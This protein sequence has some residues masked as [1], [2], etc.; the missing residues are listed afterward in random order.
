MKL[1]NLDLNKLRTFLVVADCESVT[2]AAAGLGLTRSAVSQ[3]LSSLE[4]A[5]GVQ[6]F[7]R[8][9]R[10]LLP[11]RE[12]RVLHAQL[13]VSLG[14]LEHALAD[15]VGATRAVR[16]LA[17]VGLFLGFSRVRLARLVAVFATRH[18]GARLKVL[19]A[20]QESLRAQLLHDRLDFVFSLGSMTGKGE[21]IRSERLLLQELVLVGSPQPA[22]GKVDLQELRRMPIVDY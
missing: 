22:R 14:H 6:L 1:N 10:R 16:G 9:A 8:V 19:Y 18:P 17:R 21:T 4:S 3:S 5:L 13:R 20:S 7:N 2:R 11:T 12:G 15:V